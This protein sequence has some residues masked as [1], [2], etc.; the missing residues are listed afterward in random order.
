MG[1]RIFGI[2]AA[3]APVVAIIRRGPSGWCHVGRWRPEVGTYEPGSWLR[4]TIYPQRC[5]LSPDGR[6]LVYFTLKAGARWDIGATYLAVSRLPW[7]T[8]LA[9]WE[10]CGTWTRGLHFVD[11]RRTWDAGDPGAGEIGPLRKRY[12]LAGTRPAT[13]AVERRRG[14]L[15][16]ADTPARTADDAWD[17]RRAQH[18]TMEKP[19]PDDP[20]TRLAAAGRHAAFRD[21]EPSWGR[22]RYAIVD[23][24]GSRRLD[25]VQWADWDRRGRLLVATD[26]GALE[27]REAPFD[28]RSA[29][30][31]TDL[32]TLRPEAIEP[33]SEARR[34]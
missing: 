17:E 19:R 30:W 7:L 33:P 10:T 13:F 25:G 34:W 18:V 16:S 3:H 1:P 32:G 22:P 6:W 11:D 24:G 8:A 20:A 15:E 31:T 21:M 27:V 29:S 12:G 26:A 23:A 28:A 14:W 4:G 9:A 2:P 5:D